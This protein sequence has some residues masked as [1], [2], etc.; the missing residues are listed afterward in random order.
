MATSAEKL[1]RLHK[2][3][4]MTAILMQ[5]KIRYKAI[6]YGIKFKPIKLDKFDSCSFIVMLSWLF[7]ALKLHILV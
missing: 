4:E 5:F 7:N 6:T 2:P 1:R 3:L